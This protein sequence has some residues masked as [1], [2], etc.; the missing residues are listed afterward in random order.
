MSESQKRRTPTMKQVTLEIDGKQVTVD[1]GTNLLEAAR[2]IGA[3]IPTL[4]YD[5]RLTPYGGCRLC[6]VEVAKGKRTRI[7]AS[8]CYIAEE[9]IVVKTT[10][11]QIEKLRKTLV[12]LMMPLADSGPIKALAE[13]YGLKKSRFEAEH[14]D[15][16]LCGLCVRY[17][18]EVKG[19]HA[20]FYKGRG[21]ERRLAL[22]P[23]Q[24]MAC[25]SC[26]E[27]WK[28]CPAGWISFGEFSS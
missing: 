12:E 23:G 18:A 4:C 28:L 6:L 22:L 24:E 7:V 14:W 16:V 9:G 19:D 13:R 2:T 11:E 1:E 5:K 3:D 10:T 15:C 17:C 26:R 25:S 20:V 21:V 8:C 27:C